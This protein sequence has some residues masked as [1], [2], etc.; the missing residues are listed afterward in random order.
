MGKNAQSAE[1]PP[2]LSSRFG[3]WRR[4]TD[5]GM[6]GRKL[7]IALMA[8]ALYAA[9]LTTSAHADQHQVRVTLVTGQVLT[10]TVNVPPG[11]SVSAAL[12]ALPAPVKSIVDLGT[13]ATPTPVATPQLPVPTPTVPSVKTPT[14]TP[15]QSADGGGS[16]SGS[17]G[18][19]GSGGSGGDGS[20]AFVQGA[21]AR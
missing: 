6:T 15:T 17:S 20:N 9:V 8:A 3:R 11:G 2:A 5:P 7:L 1:G 19:G 4:G 10:L 16:N 14:P 12:P 18:S 13:I 21:V